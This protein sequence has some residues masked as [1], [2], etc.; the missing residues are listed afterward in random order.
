M[1]YE[2]LWRVTHQILGNNHVKPRKVKFMT[3]GK[4]SE[5]NNKQIRVWRQALRY[6]AGENVN[7]TLAIR[8]RNFKNVFMAGSKA[9][10]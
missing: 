1:K 5:N 3:K 8:I 10:W 9:E 6:C 2:S 4:I 7:S